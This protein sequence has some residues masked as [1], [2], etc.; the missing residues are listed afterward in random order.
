MVYVLI[1]TYPYEFSEVIGVYSSEELA[2]TAKKEAI[3]EDNSQGYND[4]DIEEHEIQ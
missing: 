1:K 3:E 2:E 4:F